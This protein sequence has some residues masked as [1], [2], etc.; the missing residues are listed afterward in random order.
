MRQGWIV[1]TV[2]PHLATTIG[3][4]YVSE[5]SNYATKIEYAKVYNSSKAAQKRATR[6]IN[7]VNY[8]GFTATVHEVLISFEVI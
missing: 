2:N 5:H 1:E 7:G 4:T 3:V 6:F 8:T